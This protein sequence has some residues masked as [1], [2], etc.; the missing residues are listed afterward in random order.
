MCVWAEGGKHSQQLCACAS[1]E[2]AKETPARGSESRPG[3]GAW[4][5]GAEPGCRAV[6]DMGVAGTASDLVRAATGDGVEGGRVRGIRG[7]V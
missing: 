5:L 2:R 4:A 1:R 7:C 6:G 3:G